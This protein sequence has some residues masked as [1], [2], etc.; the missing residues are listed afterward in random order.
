MTST[1]TVVPGASFAIRVARVAHCKWPE[2][3]PTTRKPT[4]AAFPH[5]TLQT[6]QF[7]VAAFQGLHLAAGMA[8]HAILAGQLH[9]NQV[10]WRAMSQTRFSQKGGAA[11]VAH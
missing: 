6:W 1:G 3:H 8:A 7:V 4:T 5:E 2:R 9:G 10:A 11:I